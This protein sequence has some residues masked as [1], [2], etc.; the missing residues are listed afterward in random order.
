MTEPVQYVKLLSKEEQEISIPL[1]VALESNILRNQIEDIGGDVVIPLAG[2]EVQVIRDLFEYVRKLIETGELPK[3]AAP[4]AAPVPVPGAPA[5]TAAAA[6]AAAPAA[7]QAEDDKKK[8]VQLPWKVAYFNSLM[9]GPVPQVAEGKVAYPADK[10]RLFNFILA[11]NFFDVNLALN[12]A[13]QF[14][15]NMIKGSTPEEIRFT[16][17][18]P[19][20]EGIAA[21]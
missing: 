21:T 7:S 6:T 17:S 13:C 10:M 15:A 14:V 11:A 18:V 1:N 19:Q 16:F 20:N 4:A 5:A 2:T 3:Q 9:S 12:D 8:G